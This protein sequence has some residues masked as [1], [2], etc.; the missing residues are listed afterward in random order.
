MPTTLET[1][2]AYCNFEKAAAQA[3]K[4]ILLCIWNADGTKLY[5]IAG[6]QSLT[7]NRTA[8]SIEI[9]SK[10]TEG[11]WKSYIAGMK[12]WSVDN[13]GVYVADSHS[14][15]ALSTAFEDSQPVCIKIVRRE[16]TTSDGS[17]TVTYK[18]LFGGLAAVTDY[19]LE[20]PY[21][22]AMT[23]SISLAGNGALV[24]LTG[25]DGMKEPDSDN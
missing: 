25:I 23:Y 19:T 20:A 6:Q 7:I 2:K 13:D 21:D 24:D 11:G 5:A 16:Q 15:K 9:S 22:D 10:D 1:Q 4:D 8:E 18:D 17:T 12:E 14:H 3:G